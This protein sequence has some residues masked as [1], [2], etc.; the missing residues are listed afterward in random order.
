MATGNTAIDELCKL[1][2]KLSLQETDK[3]T[4]DIIKEDIQAI[5]K[6]VQDI[7]EDIQNVGR[8]NEQTPDASYPVPMEF[9][10][11]S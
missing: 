8:K 7:R 3:D 10:S 2:E 4:L 5:R 1:F 11:S 6:S 9:E